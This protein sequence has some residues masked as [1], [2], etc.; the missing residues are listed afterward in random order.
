ML[1]RSPWTQSAAQG[2]P[3]RTACASAGATVE[4]DLHDLRG[5][6]YL[7]AFEG[8]QRVVFHAARKQP[9][10]VAG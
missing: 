9:S 6:E 1:E 8:F 10:V 7:V 5:G 2:S 3:L 4:S